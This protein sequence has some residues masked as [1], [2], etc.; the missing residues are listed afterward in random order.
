ML[1]L[2]LPEETRESMRRT[3]SNDRR[4]HH[5]LPLRGLFTLDAKV[6]VHT[7]KDGAPRKAK[8]N[9]RTTDPRQSADYSDT[10]AHMP[11]ESEDLKALSTTGPVPFSA[12]AVLP[13]MNRPE[14]AE[15]VDARC[16]ESSDAT[17][18]I[19]AAFGGQE[20][21]VR[22]LLQRG[23]SVD[24]PD[25]IG[26]TA[27]M[28]AAAMGHLS[29]VQAL[30]DAKADASLRTKG[31]RTALMGAEH[32]DH[33][34]IAQLLRQHLE[35][36]PAAPSSNDTRPAAA[37]SSASA[38]WKEPLPEAVRLAAE[39]GDVQAVDAWLDR[40]WGVNR[41]GCSPPAIQVSFMTQTQ[42]PSTRLLRI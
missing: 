42:K 16:A 40:H 10:E 38:A 34:E 31:D 32:H 21:M 1:A 33:P 2:Y 22:M 3:L 9:G 14:K 15:S 8:K 41:K 11:L 12:G 6:R 18:L 29:V 13:P 39:E 4:G 20:A 27:L 17:L 35:A 30:L 23:A 37:A 7:G 26:G 28:G 36:A 25:S 5:S 24:L 19:A